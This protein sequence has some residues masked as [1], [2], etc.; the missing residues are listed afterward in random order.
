[1]EN[2]QLIALSRQSALRSQLDVVANNM[3]NINTTGFKSQRMLFEEYVM[4]VAEATEFQPT[5][6]NLSYV[7]DYGTLTNFETGSIKTTGND[8][9]LAVD[10]EGFF[11][12]QMADGTEAYTRNGSFHLNNN[13][14]LVTSEGRPVL[15][16][17][18]PITFSQQD[19]KIEIS[20]DGTISTEQG[21]SGTIRLVNFGNPQELIQVGDSLFTGGTPVQMTDG[22]IV[23][24]A[25]EQSNVQGVEEISRVIEITRAYEIISKL[26]KDTDDLRQQAISTLGR[27]QA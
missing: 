24:G 3:A 15:T 19:G 13:G 2:A 17:R 14:Q 26:M 8:F 10:G 21:I 5:D 27:L 16:D 20:Q 7:H 25:I 23:Q 22:K 6:R 12:V 9:D 1:M 18:G 11:V 4:P